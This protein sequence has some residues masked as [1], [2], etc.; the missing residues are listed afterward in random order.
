MYYG[1]DVRNTNNVRF[2]C[3][4]EENFVGDRYLI[5]EKGTSGSFPSSFLD[6]PICPMPLDFR[7]PSDHSCPT[8]LKGIEY[9]GL[10]P[11]VLR[12]AVP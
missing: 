10:N 5:N 6:S 8:R 1:C 4:V 7:P 3:L 12:G 11:P 2:L 9:E